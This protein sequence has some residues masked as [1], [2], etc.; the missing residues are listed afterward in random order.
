MEAEM[1]YARFWRRFV[2]MII[3]AVIL[4]PGSFIISAASYYPAAEWG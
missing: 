1:N 2:A 4:V 3:D